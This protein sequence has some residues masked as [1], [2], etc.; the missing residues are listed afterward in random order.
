MCV[1]AFAV[2]VFLSGSTD[3][4]LLNSTGT[5]M[6]AEHLV[7]SHQ[8]GKAP[9]TH[10]VPSVGLSQ[11][12]IE[13]HGMYIYLFQHTHHRLTLHLSPP[14]KSYESPLSFTPP[15]S[16][17]FFQEKQKSDFSIFNLQGTRFIL[18]WGK[19]KNALVCKTLEKYIPFPCSAIKPAG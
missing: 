8:Q 13:L 15:F 14:G 3:P 4:L 17:R 11:F 6:S 10:T 18:R 16:I 5:L 7:N 12:A 19:K 9:C 1:T 2:G